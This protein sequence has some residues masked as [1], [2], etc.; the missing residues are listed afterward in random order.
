M[1]QCS[2]PSVAAHSR[3]LPTVEDSV[4]PA[5]RIDS[6]G[7]RTPVSDGE[8]LFASRC[9]RCHSVRTP[10]HGSGPHL[11]GVV[12]RRAGEIAGYN[13][14]AAFSALAHTWTPESLVR[15]LSDPDEFAPGNRMPDTGVSQAQARLIADYL[16]NVQ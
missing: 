9:A 14:S 11:A 2:D 3:T 10:R 12:E 13:F 16:E 7:D 8:A 6:A 4:Q 5:G 15:F 1:L